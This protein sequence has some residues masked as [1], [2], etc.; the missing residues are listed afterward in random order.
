M[1][2]KLH[3]VFEFDEAND[4]LPDFW[5][6]NVT[7]SRF[8]LNE[9]ARDWLKKLTKIVLDSNQRRHKDLQDLIFVY[10]MYALS[11]KTKEVNALLEVNEIN[12]VYRIVDY[13][14][15]RARFHSKAVFSRNFL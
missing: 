2:W 5:P 15:L 13:E 6:E 11:N 1:W 3:C 7:V 14:Q 4:K 10:K 8:Y 9:A 12:R